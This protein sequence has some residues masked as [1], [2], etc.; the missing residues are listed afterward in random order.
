MK[1]RLVADNMK[2]WQ[3]RQDDI[4]VQIPNAVKLA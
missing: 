4:T 1:T 3:L 2:T